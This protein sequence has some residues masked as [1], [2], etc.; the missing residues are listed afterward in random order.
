MSVYKK[1][2]FFHYDFVL[3]G[4]RWYGST[5]QDTR[6][7]AETVERARRLEAATGT[8]A[9]AGDLSVDLAASQ[10]YDEVKT[11]KEDADGLLARLLLMVE[12]VG[13]TRLLKEI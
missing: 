10:Y 13:K 9:D 7:A 4:R 1:G 6:R 5:G 3:K 11:G 2:R 8:G 12:C